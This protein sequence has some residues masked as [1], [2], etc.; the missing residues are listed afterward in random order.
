MHLSEGE[1]R[2]YLDKE[3][4]TARHEQ[5][6]IHLE[7]CANCQALAAQLSTRAQNVSAQLAALEPETSQE[8]QWMAARDRLKARAS[9][10]DASKPNQVW[11]TKWAEPGDSRSGSQKEIENMWQK[12]FTRK[13]RPVWALLVLIILMAG[14]MAFSPVRAIAN[15]FLGLFRIQHISVVQVSPDALPSNL[16]RSSQFEALLSK[17]VKHETF[18]EVQT[19]SS[20]Q[21]ASQL[22]GMPVRLPSDLQ[23]QPVLQVQPASKVTFTINSERIQAILNEIGRS[24]IQLPPGING[25]QVTIDIPAGLSATYGDCKPVHSGDP[26]NPQPMG[27]RNCTTYIQIASPTISAPPGLD[28]E[29]IGEAYLQVLGMSSEEASHF[30]KNIDWTTTFVVPLP[31]SGMNYQDVNI[32]GVTG[33]I[34]QNSGSSSYQSYDMVWIKD[35]VIF[36]LHGQGA[37]A[38]MAK[39][40]QVANSLK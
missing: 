4:D 9:H 34:V 8:A 18:G 14:S 36:A 11:P 16:G 37:D 38:T 17:D 6:K 28:V 20:A 19:V 21:E 33:T 24:D 7:S 25:A 10:E 27:G 35:G 31:S 5:V 23:G 12:L 1:I 39:A 13:T 2:A 30:A 15:S 29:K 22:I 32:D 40:L 26:D 3:L